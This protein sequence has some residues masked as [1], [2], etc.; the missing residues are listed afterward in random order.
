MP[1]AM[2]P[3]ES[4]LVVLVP[5]A[6]ELVSPFRGKYDPSAG[7]GMTAH[8]TLL[9]LFKPLDKIG[10]PVIEKLAQCFTGFPAFDFSLAT[11]RRF[12]GGALYLAPQFDE[13]FCRL[14]LAVCD[15][16]PEHQRT[17]EDIQPSCLT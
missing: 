11:I 8:I 10:D 12:A 3:S 17:A 2:S 14:T 7:A 13:P 9:Y 1:G 16:Y 15:C 5:E 6:E 4:R